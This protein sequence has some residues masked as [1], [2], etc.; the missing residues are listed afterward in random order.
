LK[1]RG[2]KFKEVKVNENEMLV[3]EHPRLAINEEG[4]F[5]EKLTD[6]LTSE[7][8]KYQIATGIGAI[9]VGLSRRPELIDQ[10]L[11]FFGLKEGT[12]GYDKTGDIN[13]KDTS[14]K[15]PGGLK[16]MPADKRTQMVKKIM[17]KIK[18]N[19]S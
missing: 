1:K 4:G 17:E 14:S 13:P 11:T 9:V 8:V 19:K 18:S 16:S 2:Y 7:G 10:F 15:T 12:C 3:P 5:K 6:F